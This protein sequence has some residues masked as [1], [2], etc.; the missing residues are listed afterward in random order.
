M[1]NLADGTTEEKRYYN[2]T[3]MR[4]N[5]RRLGCVNS[6]TAASW[7]SGRG[8]TQP[9][10]HLLARVFQRLSKEICFMGKKLHARG[11][12]ACFPRLQTTP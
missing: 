12:W 1:Y 9:I 2:P 5:M 11:A 10:H 7:E 4:K 3:E 8:L 6:Q